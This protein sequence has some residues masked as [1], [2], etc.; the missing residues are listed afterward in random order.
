MPS[1]AMKA[2]LALACCQEMIRDEDGEGGQG[3]LRKWR[4]RGQ[5]GSGLLGGL[6]QRDVESNRGPQ[7]FVHPI[8]TR[9]LM[10]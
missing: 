2:C 8:C 7:Y 4:Q 9:L 3:R 6:A 1:V 10:G 5:N